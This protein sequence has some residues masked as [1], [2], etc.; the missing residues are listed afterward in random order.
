MAHAP[1]RTSRISAAHLFAAC[2]GEAVAP[3][4]D[5]L[6]ALLAGNA[7]ACAAAARRLL[8]YGQHSRADALAGI[9]MAVAAASPSDA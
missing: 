6:A 9:M 4:H 2:R 8:A 7:P 5:L 3:V 1:Q